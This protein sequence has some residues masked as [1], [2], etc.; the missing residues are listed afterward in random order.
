[1][2]LADTSSEL[3]QSFEWQVADGPRLAIPAG[4][5]LWMMTVEHE[6]VAR[7]PGLGPQS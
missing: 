3:A 7:D 1:M 4:W 5:F 2:S 6:G